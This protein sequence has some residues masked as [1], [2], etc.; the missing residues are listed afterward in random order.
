MV[1]DYFEFTG[2]PG[3]PGNPG[4]PGGPCWETKRKKKKLFRDSVK[5][6]LK[7]ISL[8]PTMFEIW[9]SGDIWCPQWGI[10]TEDERI[11]QLRNA[12]KRIK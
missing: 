6:I 5:T 3:V 1:L 8:Y 4:N 2:S 9:Q 12:S 11:K 10:T 7:K